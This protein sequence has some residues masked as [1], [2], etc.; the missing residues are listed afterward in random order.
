MMVV[1]VMVM[2]MAITI[3]STSRAGNLRRHVPLDPR[4]RPRSP[5]W[6]RVESRA[7][8]ENPKFPMPQKSP[9]VRRGAGGGR[10]TTVLIDPAKI[11]RHRWFRTIETEEQGHIV[12]IIIIIIIITVVSS[13]TAEATLLLVQ[14]PSTHCTTT[15]NNNNN[16]NNNS[17]TSQPYFEL[18]EAAFQSVTSEAQAILAKD[19]QKRDERGEEDDHSYDHVSFTMWGDLLLHEEEEE[20][21]DAAGPKETDEDSNREQRLAQLLAR[22]RVIFSK[23][24]YEAH[25]ASDYQERLSLYKIQ[26]QALTKHYRDLERPSQKVMKQEATFTFHVVVDDDDDDDDSGS[27]TLMDDNVLPVLDGMTEEEYESQWVI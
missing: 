3:R 6:S 26:L 12:I 9:Q 10:P 22:C 4:N 14:R 5:S 18:W 19:V 17:M 21:E 25:Q 27:G 16:N 13:S 24:Y 15:N 11:S 20:E 23:M 1:M 8:A 2:V 7:A